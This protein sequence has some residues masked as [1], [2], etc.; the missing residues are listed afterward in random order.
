MYKCTSHFT[1]YLLLLSVCNTRALYN[2]FIFS[3]IKSLSCLRTTRSWEE[4]RGQFAL[5]S[6]I[7]RMR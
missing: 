5:M 3:R 7:F 4:Y 2:N 6:S 1:N